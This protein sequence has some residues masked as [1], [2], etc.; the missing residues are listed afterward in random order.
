MT[1][2]PGIWLAPPPYIC[3]C[4]GKKAYGKLTKEV[5]GG[6][7]WDC[8]EKTDLYKERNNHG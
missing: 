6:L 3:K 8:Y 2:L 1:L 7:C 5:T 4:C